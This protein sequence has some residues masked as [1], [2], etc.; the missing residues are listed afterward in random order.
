MNE[1]FL[2][3]CPFCGREAAIVADIY[4][5]KYEV[6]CHGC[7]ARTAPCIYGRSKLPIGGKR[8]KTDEEARS[9]AIRLWNI[10]G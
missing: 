3:M 7:G 2:E 8:L 6:I 10:R 9:E 4:G 5:K 1:T